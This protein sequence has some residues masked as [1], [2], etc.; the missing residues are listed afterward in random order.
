MNPITKALDEIRFTIPIEILNQVFVSQDMQTC[1]AMISLDARIRE[2]VLEPRV[3]VDMNLIGGTEYFVNLQA[4]VRSEYADPYQVVYYIPDEV[5]QNRQIVQVYS[6]HFGLLG[7]STAALSLGYG[8]S[9]MG[10]E[11]RKVLD[12]ALKTPPA[13]TSY[14]NLIAHNVVLVRY[15]YMPSAAAFMRVRLASDAMFS[16]IRPT[17]IHDFAKLCALGVKAY[18][19]NKMVMPMGQAY[20]SGGQAFGAFQDAVMGYS[21]VEQQYQDALRKWKKTALYNDPEA[22]HRYLRTL[23]GAP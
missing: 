16:D 11:L 10:S 23:V 8:D 21:D 9:A 6:V 15:A 20:L 19:Y 2:T 14:I 13:M 1:G 4:P 18:I 17:A 22:K 3:F 12:S 7:Y 5:V